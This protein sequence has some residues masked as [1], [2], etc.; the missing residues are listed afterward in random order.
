MQERVLA[1]RLTVMCVQARLR[2]RRVLPALD[3][4]RAQTHALVRLDEINVYFTSYISARAS[5]DMFLFGD[6]KYYDSLMSVISA[7]MQV[8]RSPHD[9]TPPLLSVHE[10]VR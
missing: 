5:L 8:R 4:T 9:A 2:A 1:T 7:N 3:T 10:R 6:Y